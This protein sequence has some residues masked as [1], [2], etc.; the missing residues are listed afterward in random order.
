M[1]AQHRNLG[2]RH[3]CAACEAKYYDMGKPDSACPRCS[4]PTHS[5]EGDPRASAMAHMKAEGPR[6]HNADEDELPSEL[7]GEKKK[8]SEE[9]EEEELEELGE[10]TE[11]TAAASTDDEYDYN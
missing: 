1:R 3:V 6:K 8:A 4:A 7:S 9:D 10:L 11:E 2:T 5:D